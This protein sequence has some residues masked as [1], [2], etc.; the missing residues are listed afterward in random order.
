MLSFFPIF[1]ELV[2]QIRSYTR[3]YL[4]NH[5]RFQTKMWKVSTRLQTE[6]PQKLYRLGQYIPTVYGLYKGVLTTLG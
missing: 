1:L 2:Q 5:T 3:S 6:I 4:E